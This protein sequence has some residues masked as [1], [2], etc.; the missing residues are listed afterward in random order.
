MRILTRYILREVV[1]HAALGL[2]LFTFVIF[3]RDV[4][5]ILDL[6]VRNSA[7]VPSIAEIIFLTLP[8]AFTVTIPMAVL[9]GILIGLSRLASDSEITA[10]RASGIGVASFVRIVMLFA[11]VALGFSIYNNLSLAP[12]SAAAL[13]K[14]QASLR[15]SQAPFEVQPRVFYE[16]FKNY[17]LYVQDT[18]TSGGDAIWKNVF[19]ADLTDPQAPK[20]TLAKE[21]VVLNESQDTLRVHLIDGAQHQVEPRNPRQYQITSF[22]QTDAP[23]SLPQAEPRTAPELAPVSQLSTSQLWKL[24]HSPEGFKARWYST[25]FHRR[26]AP[27]LAC[28]VFALVAIPLGMSSKRGGKSGGFVLT[29]ALVFAYYVIYLIGV[30]LARQ[31]KVPAVVGVWSADIIFALCGFWLLYRANRSS[32]EGGSL[33]SLAERSKAWWTRQKEHPRAH[34]LERRGRFERRSGRHRRY[35]SKF[36]QII[37]DY[38]LRSFTGFL[39]LIVSGFLTLMLIFTFFELLGDI[40]RNKVAFITVAAYLVNVIPYMLYQLAPLCVLLAVLVTFSVMQHSNELTAMK[41]TGISIYRVIVPVLAIAA[42]IA[43][44]LFLSDQ[45]YLPAANRRQEALRNQIKGKPAQTVLRADHRWIFGQENKTGTYNVYYY[46]FF[47]PDRDQFANLNVF[48]ID[49]KSFEIKRRIFAAR[50]HYEA[51][52]KPPMWVLE[53]GWSRSFSTG[54][55]QENAIADFHTFNVSS[56]EELREPPGYFKKEVKQSSEMNFGELRRYIADLQQSGFEVMKL[57]VQLYRK[58]AYPLITLVMAVLAIPFSITR[59]RQAALTGV[60]TAV[61]IGVIYF[62]VSGLFDA[63]GNVNYLPPMLAA[64]FPDLIFALAGGYLIL[65]V[66]T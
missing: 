51:A 66:P 48:E 47:D 10:M 1:S 13:E 22:N 45:S 5:H 63:M 8:T 30:A 64:W 12:R 16:D 34:L 25:E 49:G 19:L 15:S 28:I 53:D 59:K 31:G 46:D 61:G 54:N 55:G 44:A 20:V 23:I 7:P 43:G 41:A 26:F 60:A 11:V 2:A 37:D 33:D 35:T 56:F 42:I 58:L 17:V 57:R 29:I 6:V 40:F 9:L 39:A 62:L 38:I 36:P 50:A 65:K 18:A 21:A 32:L 4:G 14:L 52:M 3:M 24:A 27:T